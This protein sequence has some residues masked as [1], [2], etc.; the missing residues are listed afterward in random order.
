MLM[1]IVLIVVIILLCIAILIFRMF[2]IERVLSMPKDADPGEESESGEEPA[3]TEQEDSVEKNELADRVDLFDYFSDEDSK[4]GEEARDVIESED[5]SSGSFDKLTDFRSGRKYLLDCHKSLQAA[6]EDGH[7]FCAVY[8][9]YDRFSYINSLKGAATGDYV[10][11]NTAQQLRRIFPEGALLTRL[12]C[13]HFAAIF[14]LVDLGLFE[15]YYEQL[16]RMCEKIRGDIASKSGLRICVGFATTDNDSSY[17]VNVLLSRANIARHCVKVTKAEK[18]ETYDET[19]VSSN[20]FGDALMDDYSECQY[21]DDFVLYFDVLY[22]IISD[23]IIGCDSLVR[24]AYDD[25]SL[26]PI[27]IE[28]GSVPTNNDK[29]F[30]QVCRSMSRWRKAAREASLVFVSLPATTLFKADID[31]FIGKCLTEFQ[32]DPS[33]LVVKVDVSTVRLDWSMCSKQFKK[34]REIGVCICISGMDTG[35]SNLD[36]LSGLSVDFIKL[37]KSY[38]HNIDK[39]PEQ[40]ERCR[41]IIERATSIGARVIFEGVDATEQVAALR[42]IN[43]K[44]IQGKFAGKPSST[45]D[46]LRD[47]P[48]HIEQRASD[49]TVILD[50]DQL[51]KGEW[52][53]F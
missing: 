18:F 20:F 7:I 23:K 41:R 25:N 34:F 37:H 48:E 44:T 11:T 38:A 32:I 15:D 49:Q 40:L 28:T 8:F 2:S 17:D 1:L 26:N 22:D 47:L 5:S 43:A 45:D 21:G 39:S 19:M 14:P 4:S 9:D 42:T 36:F 13:D 6:K 27:T 52:M 33:T 31:D 10:L 35:Y 53:V 3:D 29:I 50:E 12:S 30:Y 16:R 51:S 46:I 24:W